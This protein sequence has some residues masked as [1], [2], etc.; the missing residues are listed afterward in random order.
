MAWQLKSLNTPG[1]TEA[2]LSAAL[3]RLASVDRP[4][5]GRLWTYYKNPSRIDSCLAGRPY[6]QAQEWGLP[7]RITG[8]R[9][10]C[11]PFTGQHDG[12]IQRKE[13][14]IENDIAW[15]VDAMCDYLFGKPLAIRSSAADPNRR[16]AIDRLIQ[17]ILAH[18]G[19]ILFLQQLALLGAVHGFVDVLVK[20]DPAASA[21]GAG[22]GGVHVPIPPTG[23]SAALNALHLDF[24]AAHPG[25]RHDER[26]AITPSLGRAP[27]SPAQAPA[28]VPAADP[29]STGPQASPLGQ[30]EAADAP[31]G[32]ENTTPPDQDSPSRR[33][34]DAPDGST[35]TGAATQPLE[36]LIQQLA[37]MIR[38]ELVQPPRAL[39]L[40]SP[41]DYRIVDAY[42]QS[43]EIPAPPR[44]APPAR[45][46]LTWLQR[47]LRSAET[48]FAPA[49]SGATIN[50]VEIITPAAWQRYEDG[51]LVRQG[52]N[53]LGEIPLV[54]IQ[55]AAVPFEYCGASDVEPLIPLQDELNTRLCDRA[56][57]IALQSFKMYLAKGI[58]NFHDMPVAPGRMWSTDNETA[59]VQEFG[60]DASAPSESQHIADVREALDKVS[61]V[62]PVAA[63]AIKNRIGNLTSAAALRI[64]LISLLARTDRKRTT[65]GAGIARL[66]DLALRWLDLLGLFPTTPDERAVEIHWPSPL[67]DNEAEKLAEAEAKLRVGVAKEVVLRELGY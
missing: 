59:E 7:S 67:P 3:T 46:P 55:N 63:G 58:D 52:E 14:V 35:D 25:Q 9:A 22:V 33:S 11:E 17:A 66:I 10:G 62:S 50:V 61:G 1:L 39:P 64:T 65:Y 21:A 4:R 15:R 16:D 28:D 60:G 47:F 43:Y 31:A 30:T 45:Q 24:P 12:A 53:S 27:S 40:L 44:Q 13:V 42:V 26:P 29:G 54:H 48:L 37:R 38:F 36:V 57:R 49:L 23:A 8:I 20:L 51:E 6:R 32:A 41:A 18:N 56:H 19:G 2:A 34:P 5:L